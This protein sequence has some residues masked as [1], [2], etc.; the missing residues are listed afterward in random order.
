[1]Q[2]DARAG[3]EHLRSVPPSDHRLELAWAETIFELNDFESAI[4]AFRDFR[5]N[6][7]EPRLR[8]QAILGEVEALRN[9]S[10]FDEAREVLRGLD[11][12]AEEI[13]DA[14]RRSEVLAAGRCQLGGLARMDGDLT[15]AESAYQEAEVRSL[16]AGDVR[17]ALESRSWRAEILLA[18]GR[19]REALAE[20][21][22]TLAYAPLANK[23]WLTWARFVHCEALFAE[24]QSRLGLKTCRET[25]EAFAG[26]GNPMGEAWAL[27]VEAS[28][29]RSDDP[30]RAGHALD[31]A[32]EA[33]GRYRGP[34]SYA[35][36]RLLWEE[37]E[38]HRA[39]GDLE[40]AEEGLRS[41]RRH[42]DRR[43]PRGHA[44][45]DAHGE[46]LDAE[47]A[48]GRGE[49]RAP[50]LARCARASYEALGAEGAAR[51]MLVAESSDGD[52]PGF[53]LAAAWEEEGFALEL[54]ALRIAESRGY[55]PLNIWFVP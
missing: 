46:G 16:V 6:G 3:F 1:M 2:G 33:I 29:I 35:E 8:S 55:V 50:E 5:L 54:Q 49:K 37:A 32:R 18:R 30:V 28:F 34:M 25:L 40:A 7:A 27:M 52:G 38:L 53:R 24:C 11:P 42:V 43:F 39:T 9:L 14:A 45:L 31:A 47:L 23:R 15:V 48:R 19:Y 36:S 10:R 17:D 20:S 44:W 21:V 22:R 51:R 26:Y 12:V 41:Y 4:L 13:T